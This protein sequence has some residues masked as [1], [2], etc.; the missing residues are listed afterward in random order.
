MRKV[1]FGSVAFL[2]CLSCKQQ[3][4]DSDSLQVSFNNFLDFYYEKTLELYPLYATYNGD[5][6]FNDQLDMDISDVVRQN[7]ADFYRSILDSLKGYNYDELKESDQL[8]YDV[9]R[10]DAESFLEALQY[11]YNYL[12]IHQFYSL[13]ISMAQLGG[14]ESVQPFKTAKD[15]DNWLKRL[16][17]FCNWM[18]SSILYMNKGIENKWLL[19][20]SLVVKII[21]QFS[22]II[23]N[24]VSK[25]IFYQPILS[26]PDSIAASEKER[27]TTAYQQM[28][29]EKVTPA[30]KMVKEYLQST[31]LKKARSS[32]GVGSLPNGEQYYAVMAKYATT[33][34]LTPDEIYQI[35]LDEVARIKSEMEKVK[36]Q[37]GFKGNLQQFFEY[38]RTDKQFMPYKTPTEVL[39]AFHTIHETMRPSL[40]TMFI[41]TLKLDLK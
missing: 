16:D 24:E 4:K 13:P 32:S 30:Y 23:T 34:T 19:P 33:T 29:T 38:L 12:P 41:D 1:I 15:Y 35:G 8:S 20:K 10:F 7:N 21:P 28:I 14:G 18:D 17:L 11:P 9:L 31:Y 27:L 26:L 40:Q 3:S 36:D 22:D 5:D 39:N 2:F 25:S 6:R 37:V